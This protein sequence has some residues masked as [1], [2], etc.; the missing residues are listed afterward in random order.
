MCAIVLVVCKLLATK[1]S[2][3]VGGSLTFKKPTF[4]SV[5][6]VLPWT[7]SMMVAVVILFP[8]FVIVIS[9]A[10]LTLCSFK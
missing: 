8:S 2:K 6:T 9:C 5:G 1:T 4:I 7:V 10:S 3:R